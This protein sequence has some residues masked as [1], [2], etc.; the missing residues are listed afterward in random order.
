M[1]VTVAEHV[2]KWGDKECVLNSGRESFLK[3]II[4]KKAGI[5]Y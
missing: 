3:W 4:E 2:A 1:L 5:K